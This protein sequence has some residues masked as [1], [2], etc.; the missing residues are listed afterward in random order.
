M[1]TATEILSQTL[2]EIENKLIKRNSRLL[3]RSFESQ[4]QSLIQNTKESELCIKVW[5]ENELQKKGYNVE[6]VKST[7]AQVKSFCKKYNYAY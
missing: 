5:G 1:T 6:S 2:K 3:L 4:V 7:I